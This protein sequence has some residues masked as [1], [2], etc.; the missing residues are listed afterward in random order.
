LPD[1]PGLNWVNSLPVTCFPPVDSGLLLTISVHRIAFENL[2]APNARRFVCPFLH[3]A[4][5]AMACQDGLAEWRR[6]AFGFLTLIQVFQGPDL[7]ESFV[8]GKGILGYQ[9]FGGVAICV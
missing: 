2:P 5:P 7:V 4:M 3:F 8:E 1:W 6:R 9:Y